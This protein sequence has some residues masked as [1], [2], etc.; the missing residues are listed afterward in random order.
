VSKRFSGDGMT[1]PRQKVLDVIANGKAYTL[2]PSGRTGCQLVPTTQIVRDVESPTG[3][4]VKPGPDRVIGKTDNPVQV[5]EC[6]DTADHARMSYVTASA[7]LNVLRPSGPI[8][9]VDTEKHPYAFE[10]K[11]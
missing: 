10:R 9:G 5:G 11:G 1:P 3:W 2:E 8:P 7:P 6:I 4:S